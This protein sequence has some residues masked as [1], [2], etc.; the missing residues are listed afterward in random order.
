M[1]YKSLPY[2][3]QLDWRTGQVL[4]NIH[5]INCKLVVDEATI[6]QI[7]N[8]NDLYNK[9]G[10]IEPVKQGDV[11]QDN[12]NII[13]VL[14]I[15]SEDYFNSYEERLDTRFGHVQI[16]YMNEYDEA[17][18]VINTKHEV[19][20]RDTHTGKII[21]EKMVIFIDIT[22]DEL[23]YRAWPYNKFLEF[24]TLDKLIS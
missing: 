11:F 17:A 7:Q 16:D 1:N 14:D 3:I 2:T 15:T 21:K 23:E 19:F 6:K 5:S 10:G 22:K 4:L 24:Y 12:C 8:C 9:H 13:K 20:L 18:F